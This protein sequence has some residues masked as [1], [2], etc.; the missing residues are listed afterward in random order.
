[1][2]GPITVWQDFR[3]EGWQPSEFPTEEAAIEF[4]RQG[5]M[6]PFR[7]TRE[8]TLRAWVPMCVET[9]DK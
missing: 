7:I 5:S 6:T 1:M 3:S 4:I 8:M 2:K 9:E